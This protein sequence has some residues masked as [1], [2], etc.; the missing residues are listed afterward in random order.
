MSSSIS[1]P[2]PEP[3]LVPPHPRYEK[4]RDINRGSFGFVQLA[5][6]RDTGKQVAIKFI[7]RGDKISK[8]VEREIHNHR[9]LHHPHIIK[10]EEVF[11][12]ENFIGIS[13]EYAS[14]G[15]LFDYTVK[16]GGLKE[17]EARWFFQ[18]LICAVDYMHTKGVANR[19]MK[20]EN[21]LLT[22]HAKP[23]LKICDFGYSKS[24]QNDS[25]PKSKVGTY[26]YVAP[27]VISDRNYNG[28]NADIWSCGVILYSM[29]VGQYPFERPEDKAKGVT[30]HQKLQN[31]MKRILAV[32]YK[33]P[34]QV[35]ISEACHDIMTKILVR[36]PNKRLTLQGI[37]A[38]PFYT[39]G[40]PKNFFA[41][42]EQLKNAGL[43]PSLQTMQSIDAILQEAK[44]VPGSDDADLDEM[45]DEALADC[46][47]E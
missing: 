15:D 4:V 14:G 28:K 27:E 6:R 1:E 17:D 46:E 37:Q 24:D 23:L 42:N 16:R 2:K 11:L 5:K 45:Y 35:K 8:S 13:M 41:V 32:D 18:Q 22:G 38:H 31:V 47:D 20:L 40:L 36:D 9:G 26:L 19:D 10:F 44:V 21:S 25:V 7:A 30:E 43:P 12:T 33:F 34:K 39:K 3:L 29:L